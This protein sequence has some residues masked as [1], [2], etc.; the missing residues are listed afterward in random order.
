MI[1]TNANL[2]PLEA[3]LCYKQ[4]WRVD[5]NQAWRLSKLRAG[6]AALSAGLGGRRRQGGGVARIAFNAAIV[7][8]L[9]RT[10]TAR[11]EPEPTLR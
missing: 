2:S 10:S 8:E 4:L 9:A 7:S 11:F 6:A 3:M 1:R 5:I